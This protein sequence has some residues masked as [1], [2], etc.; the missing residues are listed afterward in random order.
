MVDFGGTFGAFRAVLYPTGVF[1]SYKIAI[2]NGLSAQVSSTDDANVPEND[3]MV[4]SPWG[5]SGHIEDA[6]PFQL[7]Q[8][9]SEIILQPLRV[10]YRASTDSMRLPKWPKNVV[11]MR[12]LPPVS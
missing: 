12:Q 9:K 5:N 11:L 3:S 1:K 2:H 8:R 7:R 10:L 4:V 6:K